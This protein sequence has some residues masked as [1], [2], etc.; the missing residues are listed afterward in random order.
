M[1]VKEHHLRCARDGDAF[2][3]VPISV[4]GLDGSTLGNGKA[5]REV[6][7]AVSLTVAV[8]VR[9]VVSEDYLLVEVVLVV[10]VVVLLQHPVSLMVLEV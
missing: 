2:I 9:V 3:G 7:M 5:G 8:L 4:S 6:I 1:E 10:P